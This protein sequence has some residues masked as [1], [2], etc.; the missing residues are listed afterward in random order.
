MRRQFTPVQ[1]SGA[2]VA[3]FQVTDNESFASVSN[4]QNYT[5]VIT[6]SSNASTV[7]RVLPL[8]TS[9][10]TVSSG[11]LTVQF[12]NLTSLP[13]TP[14]ASGDSVA[15]IASIDVSSTAATEKTKTLVE[16]HTTSITTS[17]ATALTNVTLGKADGFKLHSVKMAT[18]FGTYSTT[19]QIDI[20]DRYTFDTGMRDA[21]Y[22]L[23]SIRLKPK[24]TCSYRFY[25]CNI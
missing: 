6:A 25:S 13:S 22:G 2:G 8:R 20:T 21:F 23:A 17:A 11:G 14:A 7:G 12:A 15:L 18:A 19:N 9:D 3:Q 24:S 16:N 5:L 1:V 10:I 4:L